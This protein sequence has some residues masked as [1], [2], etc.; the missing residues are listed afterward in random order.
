VTRNE[1]QGPY[2][3]ESSNDYHL[4]ERHEFVGILVPSAKPKFRSLP[5]SLLWLLARFD[6]KMMTS[7]QNSAWSQ[8]Q[9]ACLVKEHD[10]GAVEE[11]E[12][13]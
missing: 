4:P 11:V 2:D 12:K 1:R 13:L 3:D 7:S 8:I 6:F 10:E 5:P 9:V